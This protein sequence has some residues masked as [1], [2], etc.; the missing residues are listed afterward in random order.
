MREPYITYEI[1]TPATGTAVQPSEVKEHIEV[2]FDD[3]DELIQR[4][5]GAAEAFVE[6]WTGYGIGRKTITVYA[7]RSGLG[8]L[9]LIPCDVENKVSPDTWNAVKGSQDMV[10][11]YTE[12]DLPDDLRQ[13]IIKIA[14]SMFKDREDTSD[15]NIY[16]VPAL[17][18]KDLIHALR[19]RIG[20]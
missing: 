11:G 4:M 10:V 19:R 6:K 13:A 7:D 12:D 5:I 17:T 16:K 8:W 9:P 1:K 18:S 14:A 3:H 2:D 15:D 20:L